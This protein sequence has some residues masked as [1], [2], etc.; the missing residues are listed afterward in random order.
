MW[1]QLH[2]IVKDNGAIVLFGSEP[3][4]SNL[5][6]SNI[7]EFKHDIVWFKNV[8]TGMTQ[9]KYAP[10]KYHETIS[11]FSKGKISTF[12]KQM[13]ERE[14]KGKDCYRYEHYCGDNNH[15]KMPKVKKFYDTKLV[16][17]SSVVL[18]NTVPNRKGKTHPTQKPVPLI[19]YLIKT[20]TIENETVLDFTC[21]S[22]TTAVAAINTN[23]KFICI[24]KEKE[25][26]DIS[27]QRIKEAYGNKAVIDI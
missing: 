16:N 26:V 22:G 15:V 6:I 4:S 9:S 2:R 8:P 7:K 5:R 23:R 17:P 12:N 19:E 1:K 14:G 24:E 3:F 27:N 11:V 21:G 25:Y 13:Q 20:Y 10:M 18:F